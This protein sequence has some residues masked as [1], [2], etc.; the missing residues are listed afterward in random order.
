MKNPLQEKISAISSSVSNQFQTE[1]NHF[2]QLKI[3]PIMDKKVIKENTCLFLILIK[4]SQHDTHSSF[5][6]GLD[7]L[8]RNAIFFS[9]SIVE[10]G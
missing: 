3:R 10:G 4:T 6:R 9:T 2:D 7:E 8:R 1:A 5:K